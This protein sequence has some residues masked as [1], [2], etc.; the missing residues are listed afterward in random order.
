[1]N[2][3]SEQLYAEMN[4][5]LQQYVIDSESSLLRAKMSIQATGLF[6]QRL[7]EFII[8]YSFKDITAEILFF[9]TTKPKFL[10]EHIYYTRVYQIETER[11]VG[12]KEVIKNYY[13]KQLDNISAF[14]EHNKFLYQYYRTDRTDHDHR[15]FIRNAEG[16]LFGLDYSLDIDNRFSTV[17]S[18]KIARFL[19]FEEVVDYLLDQLE[20]LENGKQVKA[21]DGQLSNLVWTDSNAALI[22]VVYAIYCRGS[23][24]HGNANMKQIIKVVETTFNVRLG[25]FYST[26]KSMRSRKK[27]RTPFLNTLIDSAE[28]GMDETD[29]DS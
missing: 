2:Q 21:S 11:P 29:M 8:D 13:H 28:R 23:V 16:G 25:N 6:L 12:S 1:M 10:K 26:I 24:N 20:M 17:Y 9:K 27:V 14:F 4:L 3:F 15:L 7:K 22:E 19:A 18:Q 5:R